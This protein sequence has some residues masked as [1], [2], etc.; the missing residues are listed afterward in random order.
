M[1]D[2]PGGSRGGNPARRAGD[3][4]TELEAELDNPGVEYLRRAPPVCAV[5]AVFRPYG[6]GVQRVVG[7]EIQ[8]RPV[9]VESEYLAQPQI[10]ARDPAFEQCLGWDERHREIPP[11]GG[12]TT[13][14][15]RDLRGC[16]RVVRTI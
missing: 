10:E 7:V 15:R 3:S 14:R 13:Q 2:G 5:R 8:L 4:E 6:I 12:V 11:A 1:T 9:P 16:R